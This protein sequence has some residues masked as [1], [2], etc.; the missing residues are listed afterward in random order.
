VL[1]TTYWALNTVDQR[2]NP[3]DTNLGSLNLITGFDALTGLVDYIQSGIGGST[4]NVQNLACDW[5]NGRN[6]T[7][8]SDDRQAL[9]EEFT[10]DTMNRLDLST[11]NTVPVLD[12]T[13][14]AKGNISCGN[15]STV[16]AMG[17]KS[18][19]TAG[20][21]TLPFQGVAQHT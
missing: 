12:L 11:V 17:F 8:R 20:R 13:C 15:P 4:S 6:L 3:I 2:G 18:I 19:A 1:G 16:R 5:D 21:D 7:K 9:V 14:S 10:Y